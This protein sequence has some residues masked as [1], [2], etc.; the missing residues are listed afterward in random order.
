MKVILDGNAFYEIDEECMRQKEAEKAEE[1]KK[2]AGKDAE[3]RNILK[4]FE[5]TGAAGQAAPCVAFDGHYPQMPH[6][7]PLLLPQPPQQQNQNQQQEL[8]P[9]QFPKPPHPPQQHRIRM[10][11]MR[12][13]FPKPHPQLLPPHPPLFP[14]HP[15]PQFV[16]AKSLMFVI[17]RF[18]ITVYTM[19][20][21]KM[22]STFQRIF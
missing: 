18:W 14:S 9:P 15:H 17:L 7:Q 20:H 19:H 16:A 1:A 13:L 4:V 11:Q 2:E 21:G 6:P 5:K 3:K 12:L 22:S 10:I 8:S